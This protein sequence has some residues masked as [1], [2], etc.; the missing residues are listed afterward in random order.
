MTKSI[1]S[2]QELR[3]AFA[4]L[5]GTKI[6]SV[7]D[8][9]R[10][11]QAELSAPQP[12]MDRIIEWV[13]QD[14]AITGR[15]L[16]TIN[17]A[18]YGMARTI[19][20]ISQAVVL[21]GLEQLRNLVVGA[22]FENSLLIRSPVAKK[23]WKDSVDMAKAAMRVAWNV[24]GI[25]ADEAYLLGLLHNS[26]ALLLAEKYAEYESLIESQ[27]VIPI[28]M[29]DRENRQFGTNH[30]AIGYLFAK[31]WKLPE[32]H[33]LAIYLHHSSSC[34]TLEDPQLRALVATLKIAN[35]VINQR[36]QGMG[37]LSFESIQYLAQARN[38]LMI[39][40]DTLDDL[41][42]EATLGFE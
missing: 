13:S 11:L 10:K 32:R 27:V 26:G 40:Q 39:S 7:P 33:C 19:E 8:I 1:P 23:I 41:R 9:V 16:K 25:T 24:D 42:Q 36:D 4:F 28:S 18:Q 30:A 20:S 38:E 12:D 31:H 21:L 34:K 29:L 37:D 17:C 5:K 22:A 3:V 15:V 35:H 2:E 14:Q 6:P